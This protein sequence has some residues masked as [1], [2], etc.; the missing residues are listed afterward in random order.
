MRREYDEHRELMVYVWQ[1]YP[2]ISNPLQCTHSEEEICQRLPGD[3]QK[4]CSQ[5]LK[6]KSDALDE[7][8]PGL[9]PAFETSDSLPEMSP[10]LHAAYTAAFFELQYEA[11]TEQFRPHEARVHIACCPKCDK[12]LASPLARQCFW[13]GHDWHEKA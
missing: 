8:I 9:G 3:L 2:D 5:Y 11:F 10:E 4:E 1:N 12:I 6:A 13:C 7:D